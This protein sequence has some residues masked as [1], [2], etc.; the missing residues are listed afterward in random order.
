M[1][2]NGNKR[3]KK[4]MILVVVLLAFVFLGSFLENVLTGSA[5][6]KP[7]LSSEFFRNDIIAQQIVS[8]K[9]RYDMTDFGLICG[10]ASYGRSD[11]Y[12]F[13]ILN[14]IKQLGYL[15]D[16]GR[17]CRSNI[18]ENIAVNILNEFQRGNK[19]PRS[20]FVDKNTLLRLDRL[21]SVSEL[22]DKKIGPTFT[23]YKY[24]ENAPPND[25]SKNHLTFLYKIAMD[26]FPQNLRLIDNNLSGRYE[27]ECLNPQ[28][29]NGHGFSQNNR[30]CNVGYWPT[31]DA[32]CNLQSDDIVSLVSDY[33]TVQSII[34]EHAHFVDNFVFLMLFGSSANAGNKVDTTTFYNI[35]YDISDWV[36]ANS[37]WVNYKPRIDVNNPNQLKQNFFSYALGWEDGNNPGYYTAYED[38]AVSME[39][40]I[41]HG[42]EF[43]DYIK[44]KP[45]LAMKYNWLKEN[46]FNGAEFNT[47]D[48]NYKLYAPDLYS[49]PGI[50]AAGGITMLRPNYVWDYKINRL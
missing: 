49:I 40:Y 16:L 14:A 27:N 11:E 1:D 13:K 20:N 36:L 29:F 7:K 28:T 31:Y 6:S 38:F 43:R 39:M 18:G 30:L 23:C 2:I 34:H 42:I 19:F 21:L 4:A 12:G 37:G 17:H 25:A 47:G 35:S 26:A 10:V 32:S 46:V 8:G 24:I 50:F 48:P 5:I 15:V 44:D 33:M 22:R 9:M 3:I 41:L 45:I